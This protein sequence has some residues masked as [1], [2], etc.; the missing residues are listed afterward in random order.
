M[1]QPFLRH[2][3]RIVLDTPIFRLRE[4]TASHPHNGH[5][6]RYVVLE[7]PDWVNIVAL[8]DDEHIVLVRQWRHGSRTVELEI[9]AGLVERGESPLA[10]G[11]R[12]LRE[13]TG[14]S[15]RDA[16]IIGQ[17]RPNCAYQD[18]TCFTVLAEGCTLAGDTAFDP[19][20]DLELVKTPLR[21]VPTL[22]RD[23]TLR[24][25]MVLL[26]IFWWLDQRRSITW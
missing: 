17:V 18:N 6:G 26:G 11:V 7:S 25:G 13:E 19:G 24:N 21:D 2:D 14:Y 4:D 3:S 20:E 16:R 12:E 23:G 5:T 10:A 22:V 1:V 15:P 8:T 9:P